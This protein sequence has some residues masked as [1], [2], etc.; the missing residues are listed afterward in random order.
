M[1]RFVHRRSVLT[2]LGTSAAAAWPVAAGA[3]QRERMRRVGNLQSTSEDD[4]PTQAN[5][6]AWQQELAKLGWVEGRNLRVDLRYSGGDPARM[7]AR[8]AELL[9][10]GPDVLL[11]RLRLRPPHVYG[12]A[13]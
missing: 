11:T 6:I 2:H 7:H 3:Q 13:R 12:R 4:P 9:S 5:L 10:F 8:A 1:T